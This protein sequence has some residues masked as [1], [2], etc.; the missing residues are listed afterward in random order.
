MGS[1]LRR[2]FAGPPPPREGFTTTGMMGGDAV[3]IDGLGVGT[4]TMGGEA[5]PPSGL[6]TAFATIKVLSGLQ[7]TLPR[8]IHERDAAAMTP[9]EPPDLAY[10]WGSPNAG[11]QVPK[12]WWVGG[13]AHLEGWAN[14]FIWKSRLGQRVNGLYLIH[15]SRVG[16]HLRDDG[17][18]VFTLDG[19]AEPQYT[20]DD[21]LH[22]PG[23][24]FDG[25]KGIPPVQAGAS[26]H[27]LAG[28]QAGWSRTFLRKG[29]AVTGVIS[30]EGDADGA[31]IKQFY[32]D[33]D[34]RHA[35]VNN[36]GS[37][38]VLTGAGKFERVT[39]PP[40][41]AQLLESRMFSREEVLGFY[42]PGLP[43]HLLGWR[44]NTSNFGTG[45]EAQGRHL[46]QHV[47]INRL[48]LIEDAIYHEL[49]PPD[50]EFT[51]DVSRL[52]RG[53][54]KTQAEIATKMRQAV[55]L[56]ADQWLAQ[57]GLPGRGIED[58]YLVPKNMERISAATGE[59]LEET[60]DPPPMAPPNMPPALPDPDEAD[61]Q[62]ARAT[63]VVEGRCGNPDCA[64]RRDG[65]PGRVLVK[66]IGWAE[67]RCRTCGEVTAFGSPH[68]LRDGAD[69]AEAVAERLNRRMLAAGVS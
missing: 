20:T 26:T 66:Y 55:T 7:G 36:V 52:L 34:E 64:S 49:L 8:K 51:F 27:A 46:V 68:S 6:P 29:A 19:N 10:L 43:H 57:V 45:I 16:V 4:P 63:G 44:S 22:I 56:T 11:V 50:L 47:L 2:Q 3:G 5:S 12:S 31:D 69:V 60:P 39:V 33:W 18:K 38:V 35:G 42:A 37:V 58:D 61:D 65:R 13:F 24:S 14:I 17:R 30:L 9:L 48:E 23:L 54:L 40:E 41:E 25:V 62:A 53:D 59:P 67:A 15:P 28:L 21:I 32:E 1:W